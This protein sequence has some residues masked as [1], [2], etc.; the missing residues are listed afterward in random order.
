M[1]ITVE[2]DL[3]TENHPIRVNQ[4]MKEEQLGATPHKHRRFRGLMAR[5]PRFC[6]AAI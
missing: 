3:H 5:L 1:A 6:L 2:G 4:A